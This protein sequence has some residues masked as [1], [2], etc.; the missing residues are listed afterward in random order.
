MR[1]F[2]LSLRS[3]RSSYFAT[4]RHQLTILS[5]TDALDEEKWL[6]MLGT[7]RSEE[8][9]SR[10]AETDLVCRL[11]LE[12]KSADGQGKRRREGQHRDDESGAQDQAADDHRATSTDAQQP[13]ESEQQY[14][15]ENEDE[16]HSDSCNPRAKRL[17]PRGAPSRPRFSLTMFWGDLDPLRFEGFEDFRHAV[18]RIIRAFLH[19]GR[20]HSVTIGDRL[21][22]QLLHELGLL[23]KRFEVNRLKQ[24][25][26]RHTLELERRDDPLRSDE[27]VVDAMECELVSVL[28]ALDEA[29]QPTRPCFHLDDRRRVLSRTKPLRNQLRV[30]ERLEHQLAGRIED[31]R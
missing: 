29:P 16:L 5:K 4:F 20:H 6:N 13:L 27:V 17:G 30:R 12:K 24:H 22:D 21:K 1:K 26:A 15:R 31:A 3:S 19:S 14:A 28:V 8:R 11:L 9:F 7:F 18:H 23:S 10:N 25:V 2:D